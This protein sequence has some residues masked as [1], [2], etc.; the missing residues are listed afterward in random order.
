M[1][2]SPERRVGV[3]LLGV[4]A[5][6]NVPTALLLV[7]RDELGMSDT[8]VTALFAV[9]ALG[10]APALLVAGPA[11]D[12]WGR[13]KVALP[14]AVLSV[15]ASLL[16]IP[17]SASEPLL[18]LVR[19]LQGAGAGATFGIGSAWLVE[20]ALR[21]G[22]TS[23]GRTTAVMMTG[24]FAIGP[25]VAGVIGEWGPWPLGLPYLL[26][27]AALTLAIAVAWPV[28][29]TLSP[30]AAGAGHAA[31]A[32][33][34]AGRRAPDGAGGDRA[35][36]RLRLRV[37]G[38]R[39]RRTRPGRLPVR[40]D[41]AHRPARGADPRRRGRWRR[42]CTP[43]SARVR[44]RRPPCAGWSAS[45]SRRWPAP[46]RPWCSSSVPASVVLGAGGGLALATGLSRLTAVASEGRLGTVS[47]AFY[48]TAYVGFGTPLLLAALSE[49]VAVSVLLLA[50]AVL[51][52]LLA[53]QQA[54][55]RL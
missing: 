6:T 46:C 49:V 24:G 4:A 7:Y 12:R 35:P 13:R 26:H 53:V 38:E 42:R 32:G 27:A 16:Y 21:H 51:C 11:A 40:G 36:G 5:G 10:L 37:P 45:G 8:S 28:A 55:A 33:V 47:A 2:W 39:P 1:S 3:L 48:I 44:R 34:P 23:G 31:G 15:V 25:S 52:G 50:L 17:A 54:R 41:G 19:F 20:T 22:S 29:E 14:A 18:F 30:D 9:Y 43:G